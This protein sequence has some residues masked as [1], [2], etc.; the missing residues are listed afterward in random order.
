M[1]S[2]IFMLYAYFFHLQFMLEL[3][4]HICM[5]VP[6]ALFLLVRE[7]AVL[8]LVFRE[9]SSRKKTCDNRSPA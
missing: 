7:L 1:V 9:I 5:I 8:Y 3:P 4:R 6:L 2:A